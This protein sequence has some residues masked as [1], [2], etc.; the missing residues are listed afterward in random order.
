[1][2]SNLRPNSQI[3]I[4]HKSDNPYIE[5]GSVIN[6]SQP[7]PKFSPT[8]FMSPQEFV[9]DVM[10]KVN[11]SEVSFKKLPSNLDI[12]DQGTFSDALIITTSKEAMN[13][14]I[15]SLRQKSL[16][17]LNSVSYHEKM[18]KNYELILN[19]L[20]PEFAE[21][22]QQKQELETLKSQMSEM[23]GSIKSLMEQLKKE[24]TNT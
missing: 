1:M 17:I 24:N 16:G 19:K 2:F 18:S 15:E 8:N 4:L 7:V 11:D 5:V 3:Y 22:Q 6:V 9:V 12:A 21:Q 10:A 14:E 20:N 23:V 13:A